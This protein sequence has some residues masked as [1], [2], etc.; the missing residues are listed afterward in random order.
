MGRENFPKSYVA[1]ATYDL[2]KAQVLKDTT[3]GKAKS[4]V[5]ATTGSLVPQALEAATALEAKGVG[6]I[7]INSANVNHVDVATYKT[8][9]AKTQG[10]M[11]T[12]EDHQLIGGFAQM[13]SHALLQA[14]VT[15]TVKSLAV[16][17][18][19]GQSSYTAL[20][21]YKKHKV[22]AGAIVEASL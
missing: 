10:R 17:G 3:A 16:H 2:N 21:L 19:F 22:D 1:G 18:E 14:G 7:V 4:V 11:V 13:L 9:L 8:A 12:A 20:E 6:A 5:I 15:F